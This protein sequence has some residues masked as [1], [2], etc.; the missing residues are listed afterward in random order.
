MRGYQITEHDDSTGAVRLLVKHRS[1]YADMY[2]GAVPEILAVIRS[3]YG[4]GQLEE[5]EDSLMG[6]DPAT[7]VGWFSWIRVDETSRHRGVGGRLLEAALAAAVERGAALIYAVTAADDDEDPF[8]LRD[9]YL[10]HGAVLLNHSDAE[11]AQIVW[12]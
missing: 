8:A 7:I 11:N 1:G 6:L 12:E 9:W 2:V 10:R 3:Q 4:E 5:I